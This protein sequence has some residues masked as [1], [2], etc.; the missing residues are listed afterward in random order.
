MEF[1][2]SGESDPTASPSD[3]AIKV[4]RCRAHILAAQVQVDVRSIEP[5]HC[6]CICWSPHLAKHIAPEC[7]W[8]LLLV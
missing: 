3:L 5:L 4:K 8:L 6:H 1:I 7:S 2:A